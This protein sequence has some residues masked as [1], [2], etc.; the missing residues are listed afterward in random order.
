[1]EKFLLFATSSKIFNGVDALEGEFPWRVS[2]RVEM[3]A[4]CSVTQIS[5]L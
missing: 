5:N 1:M 3:K 2:F 4:A